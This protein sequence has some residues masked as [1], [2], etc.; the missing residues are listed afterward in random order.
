MSKDR[1]TSDELFDEWWADCPTYST[2][3][4]FN[5]VGRTCYSLSEYKLA[6][7]AFVAGLEIVIG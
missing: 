7:E 1:P 2:P 5:P 6:R 4:A 3:T